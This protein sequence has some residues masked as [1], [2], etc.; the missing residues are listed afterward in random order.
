MWGQK[1]DY[2]ENDRF[3]RRSLSIKQIRFRFGLSECDK[4]NP[5][6]KKRDSN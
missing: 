6:Q 3:S 2:I 1:E 5:V 4:F